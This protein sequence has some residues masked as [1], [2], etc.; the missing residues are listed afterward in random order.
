MKKLFYLLSVLL[1]A[2]ACVYRQPEKE[3][4]RFISDAVK[5]A[6]VANKL[7]IIEF[8]APECEPCIRLK[9]DVLEN[10]KNMEFLNNNFVLVKVSPADSVY[11]SLWNYYNLEYQSTVIFLDMNGNEID[12]SVSYNGNS[13][14]YLNFLKEVSSGRNL[15]SVVYSTYMKD[16]LNVNS[17][18]ILAQKLIFRNRIKDAINKFNNV[19]LYDPENTKGH[20]SECRFRIA[21]C[22]QLLIQ[23]RSAVYSDL[24]SR[25]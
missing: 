15:Y 24:Y 23:D 18:Y 5:E 22:E 10:G 2:F 7:L 4:I 16:T 8:W 3:E 19:L 12:R 11:K 6:K 25:K 9:Q 21:E 14:E 13:E 17:N 1:I 20:N